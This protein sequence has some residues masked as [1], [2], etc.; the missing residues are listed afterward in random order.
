[1]S[2]TGALTIANNAITTGK[3]GAGSVTTDAIAD[4]NVTSVKIAD[5]AIT[6]GKL[7]VD[8]VTT[9]AIL[10]ANVTL[11]KLENVLDGYFIVGNGSNRPTSV[12]M[13]GDATL[14]NIGA[15]TIANDAVTTGKI[16]DANVTLA[17]LENV[18]A[19]QFIVGNGSNRPTSVAMSGDAT[20]STSGALTIGSG[21]VTS[22]KIA[23]GTIADVDIA[24]GAAISFSK[25]NIIKTDITGLGIPAS[26]TTY[27]QG[28]GLNLNGTVFSID[29]TVVTNNYTG[30]VIA[31]SFTGSGA[32]LTN[33]PST[34]L[35]STALQSIDG[36]TTAADKMIYTTAANTYGVTDLTASARNLLA[37]VGVAAMNDV[38]ELGAASR[39]T[40][41]GLNLNGDLSVSANFDSNYAAKFTNHSV[42]AT[43]A[44]ISISLGISSAL[45]TND[46]IS[47]YDDAED[48][49]RL[50]G[51][52]SGTNGSVPSIIALENASPEA[53]AFMNKKGIVLSSSGADYAEYIRKA[54]P[55][56][57]YTAGELVGI[58]NGEVVDSTSDVDRI[59]SVS[60]KPIV[61]GNLPE[62][63][64]EDYVL[65]A[66]VGQVFVHVKGAVKSGQYIVASD[67]PGVGIA[68][69]KH[70]LTRRDISRVVGQVWETSSKKER[71]LVKVGITPMDIPVAAD[72]E[73]TTRLTKLEK[74]NETLREQLNMLMK[75]VRS[76]K[77][78]S[79]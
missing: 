50:V 51:S 39:P 4:L 46:F 48:S 22:A 24:S 47:F 6:A 13:S 44:G 62:K 20:L 28:A 2:N 56:K 64:K 70:A 63:N 71:R 67:E 25:L 66:F 40:F 38:L 12:V 5:N 58:K 55:K 53:Y 33:I 60:A 19:G 69:D 1:L 68:K 75:E 14:S 15:L 77:R 43:A 3:L 72:T 9:N 34:A 74:E 65:V 42:A 45:S 7:G 76:M 59:M 27:S 26:D 61:V 36:L 35:T 57:T 10:N 73:T 8:S 52:I 49:S 11:A 32:G 23:D 41:G 21:A 18:A 31:T 30:G 54:N 37:A 29:S 78:D 79:K 17:K 16:L